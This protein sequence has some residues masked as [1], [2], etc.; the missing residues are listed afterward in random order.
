MREVGWARR[1]LAA[2]RGT[3]PAFGCIS[4]AV[5]FV[6][7]GASTPPP[8]SA[9][10]SA[11]TNG[12][13]WARG[14]DA[15]EKKAH[16]F[17]CQ[18]QG[19]TEADALTSAGA[20]CD[21]K[22]CKLCGVQIESVVQTEETLKGV[23]LKRQVI[24]RCRMI[25]TAE[26]TVVRKSVECAPEG[27]DAWIQ[28]RYTDT[29]KKE[30]CG[31]LED[32]NFAGPDA[33]QATIDAF[34]KVPGYS[35][36]SFRER[37]RLIDRA[38]VDCAAIDVRPTPLMGALDAKL[39][40]GMAS[41]NGPESEAPAF[42]KNHWLARFEPLWTQYE[43]SPQFV[44]RL[45]L[46]RGFLAHKRLLMDVIEAATPDDLDTPDAV[47]RIAS[48]C[49][50]VPPDAA[51]GAEHVQL[52]AAGALFDRFFS[53]RLTTDVE[54]VSKVL[55]AQYP[56]ETLTEQMVM[57]QLFAIGGR[58]DATEW[59][60]L[61]RTRV[62]GPGPRRGLEV[63]DHGSPAVRRQR[64]R[65]ALDRALAGANAQ[66]RPR[67]LE[68]VLPSDG[69][70][71]LTV[72]SDLPADVHAIVDWNFLKE[73]F[74]RSERRMS[75]ADEALFLSRMVTALKVWPSTPKAQRAHCTGLADDLK[76]LE[77]HDAVTRDL[78]DLLC[79]CLTDGLGDEGLT[80]VNKSDLYQR[81]LREKLP[82]VAPLP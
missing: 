26:P 12:P 59:A 79:R 5:V 44:A 81:A 25:R 9:L 15:R 30:A 10:A 13:G 73:L 32:G 82:C 14:G 46:L 43:Q 38:I 18:G 4:A 55:R 51:F 71:F 8:R 45:R 61:S 78:G 22:I 24:E 47:A 37:V 17:V 68:R 41:F 62:E 77:E 29:E 27:C 54:P 19:A 75:H 20:L 50:A 11:D 21:D 49:E 52:L 72:E 65:E 66:Q 34:S 23:D 28:V 74:H 35:A 3:G 67:R 80:L 64:F 58:L 2:S 56:P 6:A 60:Y 39:K 40:A 70:F 63:P 42:L 36:Q 33:C 69:A 76:F 53:G 16:L 31:R 7:C 57:A 1:A 48:A